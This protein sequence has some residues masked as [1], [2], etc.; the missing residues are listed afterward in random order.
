MLRLEAICGTLITCS[1]LYS[2]AFLQ[3]FH[4]HPFLFG[5][6]TFL[7]L[8]VPA[9][10]SWT[11]LQPNIL[12]VSRSH[13]FDRSN[14]H[15]LRSATS[16]TDD[17]SIHGEIFDSKKNNEDPKDSSINLVSNED[18][19]TFSGYSSVPEPSASQIRVTMNEAQDLLQRAKLLREEAK[20]A[21]S[22]LRKQKEK[23][24]S[25]R[26]AEVDFTINSLLRILSNT[27]DSLDVEGITDFLR[28]KSFSYDN[29]EKIIK[30][31]Y[32][33]ELI[34]RGD[35]DLFES[36]NQQTSAL[37][38]FMIRE[39][40]NITIYE[41]H[42]K[43]YRLA[44][45][46]D[47]IIVSQDILDEE[48][49]EKQGVTKNSLIS[50]KL[51]SIL[52][53]LRRSEMEA[54]Q[55]RLLIQLKA[56]SDSKKVMDS[57][58]ASN[59]TQ[60]IGD[61]QSQPLWVPSSMLGYLLTCR[62]EIAKEDLSDFHTDILQKSKFFCTSW[63]STSFAAIYRGNVQVGSNILDT[64]HEINNQL[65]AYGMQ[66]DEQ[67]KNKIRLKDRI[68]I[69]LLED[70]EWRAG[71]DEEEKEPK[72][73]IFVTAAGVKPT[74]KEKNTTMFTK[75]IMPIS[76][77]FALLTTFGYSVMSYA[78]NPEMFDALT[79]R[80]DISVVV[81]TLPIF[82][83][84]IAL[85]AIHEI[86]HSITAKKT[87]LSTGR[88]IPIPSLQIGTFG[89]ITE[90]RNFPSSRTQL[91]DFA[92]SGPATTLFLSLILC[93]HGIVSTVR[94]SSVNLTRLPV[95][96]V[97]LLKSSLLIGTLVSAFAPKVMT[98]PLSQTV[99]IYPTFIIGFTGLISSSLNLLPIGR[100]DGG[101]ITSALFGRR[102]AFS[103]SLIT[104]LYLTLAS[105]TGSSQIS[106][107]WVL[108]VILFQKNLDVQVRDEITR[109]KGC[110]K[111]GGGWRLAVYS[112][113]IS[114]VG[115]TLSPF[116]GGLPV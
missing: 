66:D 5:K 42:Q 62:Q 115:L 29:M 69:F 107:F 39:G 79:N 91:F 37:K 106:V 63:K 56:R 53:E 17:D 58:T 49:K 77:F 83:G 31:V 88:P 75:M 3:S 57:E 78:L 68:Q 84:L 25:K 108:L 113:V 44:S 90:I 45:L 87:N 46:A 95:I 60:F 112:I 50:P 41:N 15:S 38:H 85:H 96:P 92:L 48:S 82:F 33:R 51:R 27:N 72:P 94:S 55:R 40:Q 81:S 80:H 19:S 101:R 65:E 64:W 76:A 86:A 1:L 74:Q 14:S 2:D 102:G 47:C 73:I 43:A 110:E 109:V 54:F 67:E 99:P 32:E 59:T 34:A 111:N 26:N 18:K 10:T 52:K 104:L 8:D 105:L 71:R 28:K 36:N 6:N 22:K 13:L 12:P 4:P 24:R 89:C 20:I 100:L 70:P 16:S 93:I 98:L 35:A 21:E 11:Y 61:I 23:W 114:L 97:A 103:L 9:S 7:L 30:R 116:P